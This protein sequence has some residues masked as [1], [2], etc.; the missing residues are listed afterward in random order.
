MGKGTPS[1]FFRFL[2]ESA[3]K[4]KGV[5]LP[6]GFFEDAKFVSGFIGE[7]VEPPIKLAKSIF[8]YFIQRDRV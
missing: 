2:K 4:N 8:P 1:I 7:K 5:V 6:M 3:E